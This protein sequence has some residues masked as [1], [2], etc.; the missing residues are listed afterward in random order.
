MIDKKVLLFIL[1]GGVLASCIVAINFLFLRNIETLFLTV[2][3]VAGLIFAF[4]IIMLKYVEYSK[5]KEI[6][7]AFPVFL[8]D[9]V[10]SI[11]GGMP[12]PKALKSL[13][14]NDY[15]ALSFYVKKMAAQTD[16]GIPVDKV[17]LK[18]S[19]EVKSKL[20][21]RVVSS[22]IESHRFGGNLADTFEALSN[23]SFE[24]E[25]LK[26]ERRLYLN[27]QLITG[28]IIF[29]VFLAVMI[30]L[31]RFLIPT[32][33]GTTTMSLTGEKIIACD[34]FTTQ[35]D[36]NAQLDEKGSQPCYWDDG[37]K[38][39]KFIVTREYKNLFMAL[40]FIQGLFAG[41]SVGK[42]AEGAIISG[43]KHSLFMILV[44]ILVFT[45]L[46]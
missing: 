33:G 3:I 13:T 35:V 28:Y 31:G 29:F 19:K 23:T 1:L 17:L 11:R 46:G 24:V 2:N 44:G 27:S 15:K 42:M 32:L 45:V 34:S 40:I 4:P 16:W 36:C 39:C 21:G 10:E 12:V 26:A 9:F 20:I 18:F 43:I 14:G 38:T 30:A 5:H 41:L 7:E 25:K 8:R 22:V 37:S 6:E